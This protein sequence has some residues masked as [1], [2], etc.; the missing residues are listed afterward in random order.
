MNDKKIVENNDLTEQDRAKIE[1]YLDRWN[2]LKNARREDLCTLRE[3]IHYAFFGILPGSK[4]D[5]DKA[6]ACISE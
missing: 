5:A 6:D 2:K 4:Y 1:I 3:A